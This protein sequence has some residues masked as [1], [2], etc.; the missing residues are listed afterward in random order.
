MK[1]IVSVFLALIMIFSMFAVGTMAA[2][3]YRYVVLGD[4]IAY[5]SGLLNASEACYGKAVA[6]TCGFDYKN[7]SVPGATTHD[8]IYRLNE[9]TVRSGVERADIISISIGGNDFLDKLGNLMYNAIVKKDYKDYDRLA[10]G[11]YSNIS[12]AIDDIREIND[13]AVVLLQTLY[14]PQFDYLKEAYQQGADRINDTIYRCAEENSGVVVVDVASALNGDESN[15]ADDTMHPSAKGN[16]KIAYEVLKTLRRLGYT[17]KI[18][19]DAYTK[20]IDVVLGPGV[21]GALNYFAYFF[22]VIARMQSA[23]ALIMR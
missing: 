12:N 17:N 18:S 20:G 23:I 3:K 14:N 5:G 7:Y 2:G 15:F 4:S 1:K 9:S 6:D 13:D 16:E 22:K 19:L 8:L 21:Y 11:V 10:F